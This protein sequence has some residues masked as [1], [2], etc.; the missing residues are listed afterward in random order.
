MML[1]NQVVDRAPVSCLFGG[2]CHVSLHR[3]PD[4][5]RKSNRNAVLFNSCSAAQPSPF[6]YASVHCPHLHLIFRTVSDLEISLLVSLLVGLKN[7]AIYFFGFPSNCAQKISE[8]VH[9]SMCNVAQLFLDHQPSKLAKAFC[10][11]FSPPPRETMV[12]KGTAAS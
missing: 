11:C 6:E 9:G 2:A 5:G 10:L 3:L 8:Q 1:M 12:H 7:I 4:C